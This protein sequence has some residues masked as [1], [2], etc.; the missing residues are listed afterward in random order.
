[1]KVQ[2]KH[3]HGGVILA[4][5][6]VLG[7]ITFFLYR[8]NKKR[9]ANIIIKKNGSTGTLA[10]LMNLDEGFLAAWAK[11][12]KAGQTSFA[13]AGSS[14]NTQGGTKIVTPKT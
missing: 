5:I 4:S 3:I 12:L 2:T 13:Y 14:Y 10:F 6:L 11:G 8:N 9:Y 1:M 7:T